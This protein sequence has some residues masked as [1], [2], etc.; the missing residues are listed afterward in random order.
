LDLSPALG[1]YMFMMKTSVEQIVNSCMEISGIYR[2]CQFLQI[3]DTEKPE[4]EIIH[5]YTTLRFDK[6]INETVPQHY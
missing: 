5:E 6:I 2:L 1:A 3:L 4:P